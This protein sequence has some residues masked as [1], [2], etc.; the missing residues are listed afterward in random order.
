MTV[1]V[2]SP[3]KF[4]LGQV[5]STWNAEQQISDHIGMPLVMVLG[6]ILGRHVS[7]D[8]GE[9]CAEDKK[10]NDDA[11]KYGNRILSAYDIRKPD[12]ENDK[13]RV[14]V[15]TEWDRSVTTILLPEDY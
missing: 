12:D 5:A 6:E 11:V 9:V 4:D 2:S 3:P 10:I 8:W 14:W 15:I 7:G 13:L 1:V